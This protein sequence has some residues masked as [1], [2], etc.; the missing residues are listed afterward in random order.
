MVSGV[1]TM[2]ILLNWPE[3]KVEKG[4]GKRETS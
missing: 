4:D 3:G 2:K 1:N